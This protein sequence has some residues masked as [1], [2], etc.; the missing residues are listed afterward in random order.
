MS[1]I[2]D[3]KKPIYIAIVDQYAPDPLPFHTFRSLVDVFNLP[4]KQIVIDIS[5][6]TILLKT[7][8][9]YVESYGALAPFVPPD[10]T[11]FIQTGPTIYMILPFT[12]N[13]GATFVVN[14]GIIVVG[15]SNTDAGATVYG[16]FQCRGG[17]RWSPTTNLA[18]PL[19]VNNKQINNPSNKNVDVTSP[20]IRVRSTGFFY[21]RTISP[22]DEVARQSLRR[23]RYVINEGVTVANPDELLVTTIPIIENHGA[24]IAGLLDG[25]VIETENELAVEKDGIVVGNAISTLAVANNSSMT[26]RSSET[27]KIKQN[28]FIKFALYWLWRG[29]QDIARNPPNSKINIKTL[30]N[31][32]VIK[33]YPALHRAIVKTRLDNIDLNDDP[34]VNLLGAKFFNDGDIQGAVTDT[35]NLQADTAVQ[36]GDSISITSPENRNLETIKYNVYKDN[37]STAVT[38]SLYVKPV[39]ISSDYTHTEDDGTLF[40]ISNNDN[41]IIITIPP[42]DMNQP[43][44]RIFEYS[45][46]NSCS[47][48]DIIIESTA[49]ISGKERV[50]LCKYMKIVQ[51]KDTYVIVVRV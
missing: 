14:E 32:P 23:L 17:F 28:D 29:I 3:L 48:G 22:Y 39:T 34:I 21:S 42:P 47:K 2:F 30:K 12:V 7:D 37:T 49:L 1:D 35:K 26:I 33:K 19:P 51:Y 27:P 11:I 5:R 24:V 40:L 10:K 38:S 43:E 13:P 25:N 36:V 9:G 46:L 41:S 50:T 20:I 18:L 6:S 44:G 15:F 8:I 16:D 4:D 45:R 31:H